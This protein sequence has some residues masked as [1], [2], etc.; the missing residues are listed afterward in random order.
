MIQMSVAR[1]GK[2][3]QRPLT[4]VGG[5]LQR[6]CDKC[7]KKKPLLQRSAD[8]PSPETVPPIVH[9][10]M[11]APRVA[12]DPEARAFMEPRFAYDFSHVPAYSKSASSIQEKLTVNAPGDIYEQEADRIAD[13][14]MAAPVHPTVIAPSH[15]QRFARQQF[16]QAEAAPASVDHA[17]T[18]PGKP[19]EPGLRQEMEARLGHDF[20][21]V[22]VH[23][24]PAAAQSAWDV[25]AHA[26][27]MGHDI[28][29]GAG[30]FAP[31]INEGLR[32]IAHE[33][34]H[35]VQQEHGDRQLQRFAFAT[36]KPPQLSLRDC[37]PR[38]PREVSRAHAGA[39]VFLP[40]LS[41]TTSGE[42]G[43]LIANFDIGS[44]AIKSN[45]HDTIY[46]KQFL[47]K[48]RAN[49][50]QWEIL[51]F[52]DC[53][54]PKS[55]NRRL[56]KDRAASIFKI[57]PEEIK[58]QIVSHEAAPD[59]DCITENDTAA[60]RTLNRSVAFLLVERT[61]EFKPE[62]VPPNF[63]CG[64]DV[65][66][67]IESAIS[68]L[69]SD[70]DRLSNDEQEEVCGTLNSPLSGSWTWDIPL[71]YHENN[72]WI[73]ENYR[74]ACATKGGKPPCGE[75]VQ[76]RDQ[77]YYSGTA[78]YVIFGV[79]CRLCQQNLDEDDA[80]DYDEDHMLEL[81]DFYKG[82]GVFASASGNYVPSRKWAQAGYHGW[83]NGGT[84]PRGD[85]NNCLPRCPTKYRGM[86]FKARWCP[87]IDPYNQ[88]RFWSRRRRTGRIRPV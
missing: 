12:L 56:R 10:A 59:N 36:C 83:P 6:K 31:E 68:H 45:L 75:T 50:S 46:W 15:I 21:R 13:Q 42:Q 78:N 64:P 43:V 22:R 74:P 9:E 23:T 16:G 67:Q 62:D 14:V 40:G 29:F 70:F 51:G 28:V 86:S 25:S 30:K 88:C 5:V 35:V 80:S 27:T 8:G 63:G 34:I 1:A 24:G 55:L 71:L 33:L 54:G 44:A 37:P 11:R 18:G 81:I 73:N 57:L 39:M 32:L 87:H 65:T 4:S 85:R 58:P 48:I 47:K 53:Q 20:S 82:P 49:R 26:Y 38:E 76:V 19:M 3:V 72:S 84:P 2:Q 69:K 41:D 66:E 17:L 79:M 7:R 52:T 60:N 77:C 61:V